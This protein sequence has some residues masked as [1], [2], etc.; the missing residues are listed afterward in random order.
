MVAPGHDHSHAPKP[1]RRTLLT[2][3]AALRLYAAL[4]A[5][6]VLWLAVWWASR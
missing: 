6:A 1:A 3:P 4:A 2:S 5:I